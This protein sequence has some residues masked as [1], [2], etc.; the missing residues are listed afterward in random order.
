MASLGQCPGGVAWPSLAQVARGSRP[1]PSRLVQLPSPGTVCLWPTGHGHGRAGPPPRFKALE[2]P[3]GP[4]CPQLP[5]KPDP[6]RQRSL[7]GRSRSDIGS[8]HDGSV[9][10]GFSYETDPAR[11]R[12]RANRTRSVSDPPASLE[13]CSV[14]LFD[15]SAPA[16]FPYVA[17]PARYRS[18]EARIRFVS[19]P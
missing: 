2:A 13:G 3:P 7:T 1:G 17:G 5:C 14:S 19:D 15:R 9:P 10:A 18:L 16:A 6:I 4:D 12:Y 8:F 11:Y